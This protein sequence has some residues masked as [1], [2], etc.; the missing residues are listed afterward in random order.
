M[1]SA[2]EGL[3]LSEE[4][5]KARSELVRGVRLLDKLVIIESLISEIRLRSEFHEGVTLQEVDCDDIRKVVTEPEQGGD[6]GEGS[7]GGS[8]GDVG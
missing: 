6:L 3:D 4:K 7:H 1:A 5:S 8:N 2:L